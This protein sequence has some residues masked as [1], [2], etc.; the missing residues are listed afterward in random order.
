MVDCNMFKG[1]RSGGL[2][3]IWS[4]VLSIDF[5]QSNNTLIDMYISACNLNFSWYTTG[6]YGY[7]FNSKKPHMQG[8]L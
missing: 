2:A 7:S 6:I 1:H 5:F 8:N 3:I 4:D